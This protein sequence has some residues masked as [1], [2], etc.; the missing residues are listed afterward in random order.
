MPI[1][2]DGVRQC[3]AT[4]IR[5][6]QVSTTAPTDG[7]LMEYDSDTGLWVPADAAAGAGGGLTAPTLNYDT[8]RY[9]VPGW[10]WT[11]VGQDLIS[12]GRLYYI[13]IYV[14][15]STDYDRIG[16]YVATAQA[17]S[18]LRL[19]CY[20]WLNGQPGALAFDAGTVSGA[21]TG[22]KEITIT[23]TL[24]AGMYFLACVVDTAGLE[25]RIMGATQTSIVPITGFAVT[26]G[27]AGNATTLYAASQ[28]GLVAAGLSDPAPTPTGYGSAPLIAIHL[29]EVN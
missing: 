21:T 5:G 7:Q 27:S 6:K 18:L 3:D 15:A 8:T 12:S 26:P 20:E 28:A 29:R 25:L 22:V 10:A 1:Y 9:V 19:G 14:A 17:G 13:P 4:H 24:A 16:I 23:E 11:G 2:V